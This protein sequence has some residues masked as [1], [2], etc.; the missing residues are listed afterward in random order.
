MDIVQFCSQFST[1]EHTIAYMRNLSLIRQI[2]PICGRNGC[3]RRMT[4]VKNATFVFDGY[5]FR[6]PTHRGQKMSIRAE[7]FWEQARFPLHKGLMLAYCW[8]LS[9]S[10]SLDKR[11]NYFIDIPL[12]TQKQMLNISMPHLINWANFYREICSRWLLDNPIRSKI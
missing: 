9:I 11:Y 2:P 7:S 4:Q 5:Q 6:C 12:H 10:C 3:P 8:A 1:T